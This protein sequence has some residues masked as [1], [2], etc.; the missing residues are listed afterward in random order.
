MKQIKDNDR[1]QKKGVI[2]KQIG[3]K[4]QTFKSILGS[5]ATASTALRKHVEPQEEEEVRIRRV[6]F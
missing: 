5:S 3:E 1:Q 4:Q 6:Q 2:R